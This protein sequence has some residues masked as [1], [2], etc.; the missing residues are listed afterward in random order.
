M[1]LANSL[2]GAVPRG[3]GALRERLPLHETSF[4]QVALPLPG[5]VAFPLPVGANPVALPLPLSSGGSATTLNLLG[6]CNGRE[7]G[8]CNGRERCLEPHS[9]STTHVYAAD[10]ALVSDERC[11]KWLS[12]AASW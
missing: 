10:E 3:T 11:R 8:E 5:L 7:R 9:R 12:T 1:A 2:L 6:E 4:S